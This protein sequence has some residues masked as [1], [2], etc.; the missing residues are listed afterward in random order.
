[1][2]LLVRAI[3]TNRLGPPVPERTD[4][5]DQ[6]THGPGPPSFIPPQRVAMMTI[7]IEQTK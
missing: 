4:P 6:H 5:P 3:S 2:H 1:M 7:M